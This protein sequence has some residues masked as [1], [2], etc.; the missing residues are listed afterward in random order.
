M[1][2]AFLPAVFLGFAATG[3]VVVRD[4]PG[5]GPPPHARSH[6][7]YRAV[8]VEYYGCPELWIDPC[9]G[10]GWHDDDIAVGLFLAHHAHVDIQTVV[11]LRRGGC[12]WWD[13]AVRLRLDPAVV[14]YVD[15]PATVEPGPPYGNA[16]G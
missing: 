15:L 2:R 4:G 11:N 7:H 13:V 6:G 10:L 3:C 9:I 1:Q 16:Y 14:F 5:H 12:G 8:W